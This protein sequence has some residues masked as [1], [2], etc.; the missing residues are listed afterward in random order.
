M[1][2]RERAGISLPEF[3]LVRIFKGLRRAG[4]ES[5][6]PVVPDECAQ[7]GIQH[8][9]AGSPLPAFAGT[10]FAGTNGEELYCVWPMPGFNAVA[11]AMS[12]S[13][14]AA[15]PLLRLAMPRLKK[16][17]AYFGLSLMAESKSAMARAK[18]CLA[19]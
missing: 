7:A 16:A 12:S 3:F 11:L 19:A 2:A 5:L 8:E 6:H 1:R 10:G 14:P 13:P 9:R 17:S 15:S 4:S 18:S